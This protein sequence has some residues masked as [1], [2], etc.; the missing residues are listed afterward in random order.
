VIRLNGGVV[1]ATS[2]SPVAPGAMVEGLLC[3][4]YI[5][6]VAMPYLESRLL[7]G[8]PKRKRQCP[9]ESRLESD[10]HGIQMGGGKF[11]GLAA[12]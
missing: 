9:G 1:F 2:R 11:A 3:C 4:L 5:V 10:I 12:R 6:L 7:D 8:T